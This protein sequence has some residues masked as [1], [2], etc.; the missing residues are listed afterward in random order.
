MTRGEKM[1]AKYSAPWHRESYERF[2]T[3]QLPELLG[4]RMPLRG[5]QVEDAGDCAVNV[6]VTVG[7][8]V[9]RAR[10]DG[11]SDCFAHCRSDTWCS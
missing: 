5:Y 8:R 7:E 11:Q 9:K 2:I 10:E 6:E 3:Y 4:R 1:K